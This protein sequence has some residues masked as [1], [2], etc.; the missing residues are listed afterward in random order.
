[1]PLSPVEIGLLRQ[2]VSLPTAPFCETAVQDFVRAWAEKSG[3]GCSADRHGNL[4]LEYSGKSRQSG[5][6]WVLQAHMDHPGFSFIQRRGRQAQA[7]FRGGVAESF[8]PGARMAFFPAGKPPV[9]GTVKSARKDQHTGFL[10]CAIELDET[11][12]LPE[13]TLGM[14]DLPAWR[15]RGQRLELRVADDLAGVASILL[16]LARL[17]QQ[18]A[19]RRCYGLLTRAE[20]VGF[21]GALAAGQSGTID[22]AWPVLGI[23]CS[24]EQP[25]ARLGQGAVVRVG[26]RLT[27]FDPALTAHLRQAARDLAPL[28]FSESLMRGG[29]TES[30]GLALL[31]FKTCAVCL[32]L[33][34]YHNMGKTGLAPEQIHLGD[35]ESLLALLADVVQRPPGNAPVLALKKRM[36]ERHKALRRLL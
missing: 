11:S 27:I 7:W 17:K 24:K 18:G 22:P 10:R 8:F 12:D 14:W 33:G 15:R 23:E 16:A 1:M 3:I 28:P 35:F 6:P 29:S 4:L 26:D 25:A 36:L 21:V 2:V 32:P 34:N 13:G 9:H 19:A 30:T 5:V 20:E 31:G